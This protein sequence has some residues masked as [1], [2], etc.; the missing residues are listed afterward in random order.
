MLAELVQRHARG[1][2]GDEWDTRDSAVISQPSAGSGVHSPGEL[3]SMAEFQRFASAWFATPAVVSPLD[4]ASPVGSRG[5]RLPVLS[6]LVF[7][8]VDSH[9]GDANAADGAA[10]AAGSDTAGVTEAAP[11]FVAVCG[12]REARGALKRLGGTGSRLPARSMGV[13]ESPVLVTVPCDGLLEEVR[14]TTAVTR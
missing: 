12:E 13:D 7:V 8:A 6:A 9:D 4:D 1:P 3:A 14:R 5:T 10:G 2:G 11:V